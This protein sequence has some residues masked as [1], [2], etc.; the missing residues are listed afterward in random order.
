MLLKLK[1]KKTKLLDHFEDYYLVILTKL[2]SDIRLVVSIVRYRASVLLSGVKKIVSYLRF[3]LIVLYELTNDKEVKG[4][5]N[6]LLI[7][8]PLLQLTCKN[9]DS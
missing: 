6:G 1:K 7:G 8:P 9:L 3:S 4:V 5:L 2:N